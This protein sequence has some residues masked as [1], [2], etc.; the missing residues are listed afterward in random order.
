MKKK[1]SLIAIILLLITST[2]YAASINGEYKGNPIVSISNYGT[3][4]H[5]IDVPA[6]IY[7]GRAML[8]ISALKSL[9]L[10]ITWNPDSYN[11]DVVLPKSETKTVKID[12]NADIKKQIEASDLF[13]FLQ[14]AT[15]YIDAFQGLMDQ[16][17][18]T[19]NTKGFNPSDY[20]TLNTFMDNTTNKA[21]ELVNKYNSTYLK[22]NAN[23]AN[24]ALKNVNDIKTV[25]SI[26]QDAFIDMTAWKMDK[27]ESNILPKVFDQSYS[28]Y[29]TKIQSSHTKALAIMDELKTDYNKSVSDS[30][31]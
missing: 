12:A 25:Y 15:R 26:L 9:G 5:P 10:T 22:I 29:L 11:V 13:I 4:I 30:L 8:P 14:D 23:D 2:V 7:E 28:S 16:F 6:F 18:Y 3:V 17:Y 20:T 27:Y 24:E 21:N 1:I 31:K 19:E